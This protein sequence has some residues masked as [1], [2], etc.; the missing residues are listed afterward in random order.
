MCS[1]YSEVSLFFTFT[2]VNLLVWNASCPDNK[3]TLLFSCDTNSELQLFRLMRRR[4]QDPFSFIRSSL[5]SMF[6]F[7][8]RLKQKYQNMKSSYLCSRND[9]QY[10]R[11]DRIANREVIL[12]IRTFLSLKLMTSILVRFNIRVELSGLQFRCF[13]DAVLLSKLVSEHALLLCSET[14]LET[15]LQ[16]HSIPQTSELPTTSGAFLPGKTLFIDSQPYFMVSS[17]DFIDISV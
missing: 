12:N 11:L 15:T 10:T 6:G 4:L 7:W 16:K 1:P 13:G 3:W 14:I 17:L 8:K 2:L 9:F 5:R